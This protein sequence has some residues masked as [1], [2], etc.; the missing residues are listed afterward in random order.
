MRAIIV[1]MLA[2]FIGFMLFFLGSL[3]RYAPLET[4]GTAL[5]ILG[6]AAFCV[7]VDRIF[8]LRGQDYFSTIFAGRIVGFLFAILAVVYLLNSFFG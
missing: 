7:K 5:F 6:I 2:F 4:L 1:V 3:Y 8:N